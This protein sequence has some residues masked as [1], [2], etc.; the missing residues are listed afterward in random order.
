MKQDKATSAISDELLLR[1]REA[2]TIEHR[3]LE[4]ETRIS[5]T[6]HPQRGTVC[7]QRLLK[8]VSQNSALERFH[9]EAHEYLRLVREGRA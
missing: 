2:A 7:V 4:L 1:F 3:L 9:D 8:L 6:D 5:T